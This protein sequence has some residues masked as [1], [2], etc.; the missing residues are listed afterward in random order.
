[1]KVIFVGQN[2]VVWVKEIQQWKGLLKVSFN[3]IEEQAHTSGLT[4]RVREMLATLLGREP[5][6]SEDSELETEDTESEEISES[7]DIESEEVTES[8]DIESEE[9][10][11]EQENNEDESD[12]S[13]NEG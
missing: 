8:E 2:G 3:M 1:M 9:T 6:I 12:L 10:E 5:E 4:D 13:K 11:P 7:E